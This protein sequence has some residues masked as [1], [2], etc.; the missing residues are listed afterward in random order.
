M[1]VCIRRYEVASNKRSEGCEILKEGAEL[2]IKKIKATFCG[3]S[4]KSLYFNAS[5]SSF[6]LS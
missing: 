3:R 2:S 6:V 4:K 1:Y 5:A